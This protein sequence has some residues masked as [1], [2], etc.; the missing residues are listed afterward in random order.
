[1][2]LIALD[3]IFLFDAAVPGQKVNNIAESA[4]AVVTAQPSGRFAGSVFGCHS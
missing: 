3:F 1:V 2:Q 4:L